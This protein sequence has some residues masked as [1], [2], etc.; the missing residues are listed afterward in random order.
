M[1]KGRHESFIPWCLQSASAILLRNI[2]QD[3]VIYKLSWL[4]LS[5]LRI[6]VF[7]IQVYS[8]KIIVDVDYVVE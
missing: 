3:D 1:L 2:S 7:S 5:S 4:G 8:F 6:P